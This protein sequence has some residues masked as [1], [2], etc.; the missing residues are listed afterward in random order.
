MAD[1]RFLYLFIPRIVF[2]QCCPKYE[3]STTFPYVFVDE[4]GTRKPV[5]YFL[6]PSYWT[7]KHA[8]VNK[9]TK[10]IVT[11]EEVTSTC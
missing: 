2:R 6:T 7:G 9:E 11:T 4:Y 10:K 1:R 3:H 5:Y 8:I